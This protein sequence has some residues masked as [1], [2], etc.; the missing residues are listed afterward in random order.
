M[1]VTD[2]KKKEVRVFDET[3]NEIKHF[4]SLILKNPRGI[5]IM[6]LDRSYEIIVTD[7][8]L[9]NV[10]IFNPSGALLRQYDLPFGCPF[11]VTEKNG[12]LYIVDRHNAHIQ[13][14]NANNGKLLNIVGST[15]RL[16][17]QFDDPHSIAI[18]GDEMYITD[19]RRIQI[20]TLRGEFV[21][22]PVNYGN[23]GP[24]F[25]PGGI[26]VAS[27]STQT[28]TNHYNIHIIVVDM[29]SHNVQMFD[30]NGAY[31]RSIYQN[32]IRVLHDLSYSDHQKTLA[33]A[34]LDCIIL[35]Q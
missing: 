27:A 28:S 30:G 4:G 15:G 9:H 6:V 10:N 3:W 22:V 14:M 29:F 18:Y 8:D 19:F 26:L 7:S 25:N 24:H 11:S 32:S 35:V 31:I 5:T 34:A 20:F 2:F 23:P 1:Y 13:I 21:S 16:S 17:Q 12:L 33:I